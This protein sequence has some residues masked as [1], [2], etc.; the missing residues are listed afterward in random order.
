MKND[1]IETKRSNFK[2]RI[3]QK[4]IIVAPG[5]YDAFS[6]KLIEQIGFEALYITGAGISASLLGLPDIG[7]VTM[8]EMVDQAK[9][10][11]DATSLPIICDAD[12]GYG[13][14]L[15]VM[16]TVKE[17]EKAGV[18][19]I[20]IEDQVIPKRCGHLEGKRVISTDQM[21]DKLKAALDTREDKNFLIIARTDARA[22]FGLSEAIERGHLYAEAGADIIFVEAP[23]SIEELKEIG[24]SFDNI[25]ILINRG[26]GG[27]TPALSASDLEALGFRIV[28]F[29]GDAQR[30][31]GKAILNVM[32][33]LK[34][35]GNTDKVL[36]LMM[37][38]EERFDLLGLA[39][40]QELESLYTRS[41]KD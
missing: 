31:A 2:K 40:F 30:A 11:V 16:R 32:K 10:I 38:F 14:V 1:S 6:A 3:Q 27:K 20:H 33:S 23:E 5:A 12:T 22:I 18:C 9:R 36:D 4:R 24:K 13:G 28:I 15:N 21:V 37:S 26:G 41:K 25:P 8:N 35:T 34:E 29:P 17:F 39:R 19:A 7:L